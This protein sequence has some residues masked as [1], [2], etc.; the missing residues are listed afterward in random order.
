MIGVIATFEVQAGKQAEFETV[1]KDLMAKVKGSESGCLT[2]QLY[3][4][5]G[6]DTTYV[7]MEQYAN[8][9]ALEEHT[10]T[11]Y[12]KA[13]GAKFTPC[14]AGRPIVQKLDIIE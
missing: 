13:V 1:A 12:Y 2:Y 10:K 8:A 7:L 14:L 11:D 4:R 6:S 9:E 5:Q 3:K